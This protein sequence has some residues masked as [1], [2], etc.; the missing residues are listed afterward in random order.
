M[1]KNIETKP[2]LIR[3]LACEGR[4]RIFGIDSTEIA[5][6]AQR[7]HDLW[8]TAS[9]AL[10]RVLS[11][12]SMMGY[13]LKDEKEKLAIQING[14]GPIGTI[15][16]DV[17]ANGDVRGFVG[18]P[19]THY[20]YNDTGKLAVGVAVGKEGYLKV[21]RDLGM[22]E[23]FTGQVALQ[24]GEIGDDFAYY[25]AASEQT[26]SV[27]S[28]G[29]LVDTDNTVLAA[30]GLIIQMLPDAKEEDILK[31]EA[32]LRTLKP[33]S[34]LINEGQSIQEIVN[35]L[36]E[37]VKIL[38]EKEAHF[39]CTCSEATMK[40]ALLTLDPKEVETMIEE[41]SGAEV[42]CHWCNTAYNFDKESLQNLLDF[43]AQY[44]QD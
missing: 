34:T 7:R 25:F 38:E 44:R 16:V 39:R 29:V 8:P 2:N 36:Y 11:A 9:A 20:T 35:G 28:L 5:K 17:F 40:R 19:H 12:G 41:D 10:G 33:M 31:T 14:G 27:V 4:V 3:A 15:M 21:I 24:T 13:M 1:E 37:D 18:E 42:V 23:D 22:K 26:P 6:E 43:A 30:G 32:V